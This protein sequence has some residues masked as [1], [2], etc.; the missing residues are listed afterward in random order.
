MSEKGYHAVK[1]LDLVRKVE[2]VGTKG[3]EKVGCISDATTCE[4]KKK[5]GGEKK[6]ENRDSRIFTIPMFF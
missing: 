5:G 1:Q 4:V 6:N 3:N 2:R